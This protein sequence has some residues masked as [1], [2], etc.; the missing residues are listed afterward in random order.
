MGA[1]QTFEDA[2]YEV[3]T[4]RVATQPLVAELDSAD[5]RC[6]LGDLQQLDAV[7]KAQ[8]VNFS[9]GPVIAD[10]R[11][12]PDLPLWAADLVRSTA[13]TSFSV[14]VASAARGVH[15]QSC[16][17]AAR[18]MDAIAQAVPCGEGNFRFAAAAW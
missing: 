1:R 17:S 9:I 2:G 10:D 14:T 8:N 4:V 12:D 3:Q 13:N 16:V 7:V 6:A 15:A 5:R 18:V 11:F